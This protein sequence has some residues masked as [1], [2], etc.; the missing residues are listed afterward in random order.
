ML[1]SFVENEETLTLNHQTDN[2]QQQ[3]LREDFLTKQ[4][5]WRQ[6]MSLQQ[7]S[8]SDAHQKYFCAFSLC[9]IGLGS[10]CS[11]QHHWHSLSLQILI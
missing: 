6:S 11:S 1:W 3:L 8:H 10:L 2:W 4:M 5:D 7:L 9:Q